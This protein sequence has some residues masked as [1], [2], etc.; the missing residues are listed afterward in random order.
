[1]AREYSIAVAAALAATAALAADP[2]PMELARVARDI[3]VMRNVRAPFSPPCRVVDSSALRNELDRK[4]RRDLPL[5]PELFLEALARTGMVEGDP[6]TLYGRLLD[7]YGA[8]VLGFY[9]PRADEMVLIEGGTATAMPARMVW[10]HEVAH[11]AQEHR[12]KLPSRLLAIRDSGDAQRA[13]STIA[14]GEAMLVMLLLETPAEG[15]EAVLAGAA[16]AMAAQARS[17]PA[18]AGIPDYFVQDLLFPYTAGLAAVLERYRRS[19]WRGVDELLASPPS[20]TAVL[21]YPA[22]GPPGPP[23]GDAELPPVPA[24]WEE[25]LVDTI[26]AW[27]LRFWLLRAMPAAD[28]EALASH[29]DGDRLRLVRPSAASGCWSLAWRLRCRTEGGRSRFEVALQRHLPSLLDDLCDGG[30]P[31]SLTWSS[32]GRTLDLR[33]N[34]PSTVKKTR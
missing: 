32:S 2:C 11:A 29:W 15:A 1:M 23:V 16:E 13:A 12:F 21:L 33:A 20:A 22:L 9:E 5:A 26:G 10:A 3:A 6:A 27:G 24:G 28:A 19:G 8:Q 4:L 17:F 14:E 18:P 7:F 25:I 31:V 30:G 34:W